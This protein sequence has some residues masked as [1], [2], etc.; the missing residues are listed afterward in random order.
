MSRS[1]FVR[2]L[3]TVAL[4]VALALMP[5]FAW[6]VDVSKWSTYDIQ[7]TGNHHANG[8]ADGTYLIATFTAPDKSTQIVSGF[9]DGGADFRVRFVPTQTGT[10]SYTIRSNDAMLNSQSGTINASAAKPGEHGFLRTDPKHKYCFVWDDGTRYFMWGQIYDDIVATALAT[11]DKV[12]QTAIDNSAAHG[13]SK[14]R[15]NVCSDL[16]SSGWTGRDS[17]WSVLRHGYPYVTVYT[18][19]NSQQPNRDQLNLA[20]WQKLDQIIDYIHSKGLVADLMIVN[21]YNDNNVFGTGAQNDRLI[22][23]TVSRYAAYDN[24]IWCLCW[25]WGVSS[26]AAGQKQHK[27]DFDRFGELVRDNDPWLANGA[28]MR[29]LTIHSNTQINFPFFGSR[30]PTEVCIQFGPR[31]EKYRYGDQWGNAGIVYNLGHN[32]PVVNDEYGYINDEGGV[33]MTRLQSRQAIWGIAT[34]GGY[35]SQGDWTV[36]GTGSAKWKPNLTGEW[37]DAAEYDDIK[38]LV[39]FFTTK[40]IE[41]WKMSSHNE[42]KSGSSRAYLLAEPGRQY[43]LYGA[44]EGTVSLKLGGDNGATFLVWKYD[45][46]SGATTSLAPVTGGGTQSWNLAEF[47]TNAVGGSD[48]VLLITTLH[49]E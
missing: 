25:E 38:H 32:M 16:A 13:F 31:N 37:H 15:L 27:A 47:G 6:A 7:L 34:A 14:I 43:V 29:P 23:Y 48:W 35:G 46:T 36:Y 42:L 11:S 2:T 22:K 20:Y 12:W 24:V 41:Y 26:A 10:W 39:D 8:Y 30:W 4:A 21:P 40:G 33:T 5:C 19:S 3:S 28:A 17:A 18:A 44:K 1:Q 45:P 9:W 49:A